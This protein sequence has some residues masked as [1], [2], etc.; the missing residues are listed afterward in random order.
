MPARAASSQHRIRFAWSVAVSGLPAGSNSL[1]SPIASPDW[2]A[3]TR[4]HTGRDITLAIIACCLA[5]A[6]CGVRY[7]DFAPELEPDASH[8]NGSGDAIP[9]LLSLRITPSSSDV[10]YD[11][12]SF[13]HPPVFHAIGTFPSGVRDVTSQVS[14]SLARPE[15]GSIDGGHFASAA[16]GG[17]AEIRAQAGDK[18]ALAELRVRL[19]ITVRRDVDSAIVDAFERAMSETDSSSA[20]LVYP[21]TDAVFP[22]NFA[23]L[24]YQWRAPAEFD[25]FELRLDS[26]YTSLRYYTRKRDWLD[27][28]ETSRYFAPSSAGETVQIRV[29]ALESANPNVVSRSQTVHVQVRDEPLQGSIYYWSSTARGIK[30][31][32]LSTATA[33]RVAPSGANTTATSCIGCHVVSRDGTHLAAADETEKLALFTLPDLN[34]VTWE[35][36]APPAG[37]PPP[38]PPAMPM[39]MPMPMPTA[40][41]KAAMP[42]LP[43]PPMAAMPKPAY[44]WGSFNPDSTQL[45]Y[46]AK[47]KLHIFDTQR[48]ME[49]PKVMLPPDVSVT[50]PDWA[51]DG[52]SIAV[53]HAMGKQP[54]GNKLVRGSNIAVML[55]R[56]D[57]SLGPPEP[58]VWSMGPDDTL[59][60]PAFSPDGRWIAYTRTTGDSK[61]NPDAELYV[62]AADRSGQPIRLG[63]ANQRSD[64]DTTSEGAANTMPAWVPGTSAEV[65]FL[66]F[67]S[68]RD[69][70]NVTIDARRDQLWLTAID[71]RALESAQDPSTPPV[72]L[73]M[74][75]PFENNHRAFWTTSNAEC[76]PRELCNDRDDD[77]DGEV[78]ESCCTPEPEE[79]CGDDVDNDCD[80]TTNE[81]C[82]CSDVDVCDNNV[83]DDCDQN[84]DEYCK[85]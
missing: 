63:R 51:P 48:G 38:P 3:T 68:T 82:L 81:G 79:I 7:V 39:P 45:A 16:V 58:V 29:T 72:W 49:L 69:Y 77:C 73:P 28:I 85:P 20:Q 67:S 74:Q 41:G 55:V 33:Y 19:E 8:S 47:G 59:S 31:G 22:S 27:D 25:R 70:A 13:D 5:V 43:M 37:M 17:K 32:D 6:G 40:P 1:T 61:D 4:A 56:E 65:G 76:A 54:K 46:A 71:F 35:A 66:A 26:T 21:V 64:F 53:T 84:V 2:S 44:G 80:G 23:D 57:G 36:P 83:D 34:T 52:R 18:E 30:R 14:W 15:L 75:D 10:T 11:G 9:D 62:V 24:R 60:F 50:H 42:K 12:K 78:D